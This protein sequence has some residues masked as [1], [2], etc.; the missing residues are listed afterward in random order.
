MPKN[1]AIGIYVSAFL[2]LAGFGF[3]WHIYWLILFGLIGAT[4][5]FIVRAFS[6]NSEYEITAAE[7]KK[8]EEARWR[9]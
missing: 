9:E 1:T 7:L 4:I 6:D 3:V 5:C 2:F 8:M